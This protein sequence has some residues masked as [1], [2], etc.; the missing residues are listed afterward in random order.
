MKREP[1]IPKEDVERR[2]REVIGDKLV[3]VEFR[4][5]MRRS[6]RIILHLEG[7]ATLSLSN[8]S[9]R[10]PDAVRRFA[11]Q[12]FSEMEETAAQTASD[13]LKDAA[14]ATGKLLNL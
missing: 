6:E 14:R 3:R 10:D 5:R 2:A 4:A 7:K 9:Y 11:L 13:L 12:L 1:T 8:D